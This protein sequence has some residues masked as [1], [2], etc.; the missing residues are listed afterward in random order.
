MPVERPGSITVTDTNTQSVK[1]QNMSAEPSCATVPFKFA[2]GVEYA[3]RA[4]DRAHWSCGRTTRLFAYAMLHS[5]AVVDASKEHQKYLM[6]MK[7]IVGRPALTSFNAG[8]ELG[9]EA[10]IFEAFYELYL[11]GILVQARRIVNELTVVGIAN[12]SS[13][14][15]SPLSWAESHTTSMIRREAHV[16]GSW[17]RSVCDKQ[18]DDVDDLLD[19]PKWQAPS[20]LGMEPN[21]K[22]EWSATSAWERNDEEISM[23]WLNSFED[24]YVQYLESRVLDAECRRP[25]EASESPN[26]P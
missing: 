17:V 22:R 19:L 5:E 10:S 2:T 24:H 6:Y 7:S 8:I 12:S 25:V 9:T 14:A 21:C 16:V 18:P 3:R 23:K 15:M 4:F 1:P 11:G 20:F 13:I 26:R